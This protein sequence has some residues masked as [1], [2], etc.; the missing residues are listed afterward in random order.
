MKG[1]AALGA[2]R[3]V[4]IRVWVILP[5]NLL[6]KGQM[7]PFSFHH[8]GSVCL[9]VSLISASLSVIANSVHLHLCCPPSVFPSLDPCRSLLFWDPV[10]LVASLSV[11]TCV[12]L[13]T[14]LGCEGRAGSFL[15]PC[16][17]P[18]AYSSAWPRGPR[19]TL[20]GGGEGTETP[21]GRDPL[22]CVSPSSGAVPPAHAEADNQ[23]TFAFETAHSS[24]A[25][26]KILS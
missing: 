13:P 21:G 15:V 16:S 12:F 11:L 9:S 26:V 18:T 2:L 14:C 17:P 10:S 3:A 6:L 24:P 20:T 7:P 1:A 5:Q 23:Q 8:R 22:S 4:A 19:V 25:T